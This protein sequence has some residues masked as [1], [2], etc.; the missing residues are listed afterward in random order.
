MGGVLR[1][2]AACLC[3]SHRHQLT[4]EIYCWAGDE[5]WG[6]LLGLQLGKHAFHLVNVVHLHEQLGGCPH[7]Q[8]C[9]CH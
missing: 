9:C 3:V 7:W 6:Q 8:K 2:W 4:M 5:D 1:G